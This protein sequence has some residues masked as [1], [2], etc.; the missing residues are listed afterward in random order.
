MLGY[1]LTVVNTGPV[2]LTGAVVKDDVSGLVDDATLAALPAAVTLAGTELTW[3]VPTVPVGGTAQV[4]Y[5]AT[6][7]ALGA[8]IT[9]TATPATAGGHCLAGAC[10]TTAYTPRWTLTKDSTP[11]DAATVAPGGTIDYRLQR[12]EHRSGHP[13]RGDR[14]RR[15]RRRARRRRPRD[16]SCGPHA[17]RHPA[18]LGRARRGSRR[19][20]PGSAYRVQVSATATGATV[21][22]VAVPVGVGGSCLGACSTTQYTGS[23]SLAKTSDRPDG[24]VVEPGDQ[25]TYTLVAT[26][27]SAAVVAG[28]QAHDD[29]SAVLDDAT[30]GF[31]SSELT[32]AGTTLTWAV[33][34]LA[35]GGSAAVS[36]TVRVRDDARGATLTNSVS[37]VGERRRLHR[38]QHDPV[39]RCLA[40]GEVQ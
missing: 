14:G 37:P 38:V 15:A 40:A 21:H 17:L 36:Y 16:A 4:T 11:V 6:V 3:A 27:T 23:W 5:T 18:H 12:H 33:P 35:P 10:I 8:T 7:A 25:I 20:T 9:N 1:T 28:A 19:Y 24:A 32:R 26:N 31:S 34:T 39:H 22:N 13:A 2:P 30:L 29:L